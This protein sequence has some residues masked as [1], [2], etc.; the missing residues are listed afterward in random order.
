MGTT[1]APILFIQVGGPAASMAFPTTADQYPTFPSYLG[2][3][4]D[5]EI[6]L[7]RKVVYGWEKGRQGAGRNPANAQPPLAPNAA[8]HYTI[9]GKQFEDGEVNQKMLLNTAEEWQITNQTSVAHPFHI[10]VNPFQIVEI[11]DPNTMQKPTRIVSPEDMPAAQQ[12]WG[13]TK[14]LVAGSPIWWDNFAIP[15]AQTASGRVVLGSDG[16]AANPGYFT[17]RSRF[18]DFTG[19]YVQHCHILAHEDRGMM[20]LLEVVTNKTVLKHH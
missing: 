8:P 4:L 14:N 13:T 19:Q 7:W 1:T 9:D 6:R 18:V 17:M 12:R 2:D 5:R 15:I 16:F 20:Q 10:H 11:Y 3:I